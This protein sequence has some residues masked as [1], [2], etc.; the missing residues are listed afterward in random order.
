[1]R[2]AARRRRINV[3][4]SAPSFVVVVVMSGPHGNSKVSS[5]SRRRQK[6]MKQICR[7]TNDMLNSCS[8]DFQTELLLKRAGLSAP[9]ELSRREVEK[10]EDRGCALF[11]PPSPPRRGRPQNRG[12]HRRVAPKHRHDRRQP[13]GRNISHTARTRYVVFSKNDRISRFR[14]TFKVTAF[15]V[16]TVS[17]GPRLLNFI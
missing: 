4:T 1:M 11:V 6:R 10:R 17:L 13:L 16:N 2:W 7:G 5:R 14:R 15:D 12:G 3:R 9:R 8:E